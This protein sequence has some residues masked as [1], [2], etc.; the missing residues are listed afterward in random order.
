MSTPAPDVV[1]DAVLDTMDRD[2]W[3]P[4]QVRALIASYRH[5]KHEVASLRRD[6]VSAVEKVRRREK[7]LHG[8]RKASQHGA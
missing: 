6:I 4:S 5:L 8:K 7:R 2:G 3:T 1:S